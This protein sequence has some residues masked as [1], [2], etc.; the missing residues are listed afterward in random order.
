MKPELFLTDDGSHSLRSAHFPDATYHSTHGAINESRHI[1]LEAGLR[2]YFENGLQQIRILEMGFGTGLNALLTL[3]SLRDYPG[4][5]I[6][7]DTYEKFPI[8]L[9]QAD[10]L[11]YP[12]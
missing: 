1:F 6:F 10:S 5:T 2:R 8:D 11:N 7:Y 4:V 3:T 9:H 12:E